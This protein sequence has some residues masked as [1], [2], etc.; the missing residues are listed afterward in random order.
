MTTFAS[1]SASMTATSL[2]H[3]RSP[4]RR[5]PRDLDTT[6]FGYESP[7]DTPALSR[8]VF[9]WVQS[10]DLSHALKNVRRYAMH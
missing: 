7:P 8:E 3:T 2:G 9:K 6:L 1:T 4:G 5:V 10:L